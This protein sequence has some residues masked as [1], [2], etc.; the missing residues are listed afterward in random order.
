[1]PEKTL[2]QTTILNKIS[3]DFSDKVLTKNEIT[4]KLHIGLK[5]AF[6]F[7]T[8]TTYLIDPFSNAIETT[9]STGTPQEFPE[10]EK[11]WLFDTI[12]TQLIKN[13]AKTSHVLYLDNRENLPFIDKEQHKI[14]IEK[15]SYS[16]ADCIYFFLFSESN[17]LLGLTCANNWQKKEKIGTKEDV[18]EIA[19]ASKSFFVKASVAIDNLHIHKKIEN[20]LSDKLAL[21]KRIKQDEEGL[22]Q[23]ILELTALY[24]TSNALGYTLNYPQMASVVMDTLSQV[25]DFD[26]CTVFIWGF[27]PE[28]EIITR[29]N[30]PLSQATIDKINSNIISS[31]LPFVRGAIDEK[32]VKFSIEKS[33]TSPRKLTKPTEMKSFANVPLIFKEEV[34]GFLNVCSSE[35]NVFPRNEMTFLHTMSNQLASNLGRIKTIK[36]LEESKISALIDSMNDGVIMFDENNLLK[37]INPAVKTILGITTSGDIS[38]TALDFFFEEVNLNKKFKEIIKFKTSF[39]NQQVTYKEKS[40]SVNLTPVTNPDIGHI[41]TLLVFRDI[42]EIQRAN[43][44]KE[45]RLEVISKMDEILGSTTDLNQ[46]LEVLMPFILNIAKAEQ[47][48]IQLKD[49][50]L[51]FSKIH[52]NFPDKI[53]RHYKLKSG[54]TISDYVLSTHELCFIES[55]HQNPLVIHDTKVA[56]DW[57]LCI[58]IKVKNEIIGLINIVRKPE[59]TNQKIT[60]DDITTLKTITTLCGTAIQNAILYQS[61]LLKEKVDQELKVAKEIQSKL[62]PQELPKIPNVQFGTISIPA[63]QI[64]GDYYDFFKLENGKIGIVIAD[65]VGKGIPA[66]LFMATLKSILHN[67]ISGTTSPQCA[68]EKIN[69]VLY[70]DP[71]IKKFVP[72][73]YGILNPETFEFK[74]C[75]AGHE[76]GML[77]SKGKFES[78]DTSGFPLGAL[79]ETIYE[80]KSIYLSENDILI[81]F[82]DGIIEARNKEEIDFG[83]SRLKKIITTHQSSSAEDLT[84][85]IYNNI[86]KFSGQHQHDDLT[87]VTLKIVMGENHENETPLIEKAIKLSSSK[88]NVKIVRNLLDELCKELPFSE[89]EVFDIKLAV[90]EAHANVIEHAYFGSEE[91]DI[92]F[93]FFVYKNRIKI[94]IRDFGQGFGQKTTKTKKEHLNELEGSGLGVFLIRNIMDDVQYIQHPVGTELILVK[95][96]K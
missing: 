40:Y 31:V 13:G 45:Q 15:N 86:H 44:I 9:L 77:F 47:G 16:C 50:K 29:V 95:V 60:E 69:Q 78:L 27:I 66:G 62:L 48:S 34:I 26:I 12:R 6:G 53:R 70:N 82:T 22:K 85:K 96:I 58:P 35:Q 18:I 24:D 80:E 71:V 14:E 65:I 90:N 46:L 49:G 64:G 91:G 4:K 42:T 19:K 51:F 37:I 7:S 20:L 41:G 63:R 73:F 55:Y 38:H 25:L 36:K 59:N 2:V 10:S 72:V 39:L 75:N 30:K 8:I 79:E 88:Q 33:Y 84:T 54:Q 56:I 74:Y 32:K 68:L 11:K 61:N 43:R 1:M 5:N 57:Y 94:S 21:T 93:Q 92:H 52:S 89:S 23:R 81:L 83:Y 3:N 67:H 28:G 76:P 17:T 87:I